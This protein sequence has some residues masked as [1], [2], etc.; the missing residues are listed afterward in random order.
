MFGAY[1]TGAGRE[2]TRPGEDYPHTYH[3]SDYYFTWS[4]GRR[5]A[6]WEY[7]ILYIRSGHGVIEFQ[8]GKPLILTAGSL[9]I[10]HPGEWHRYRPNPETGW[11]EAYVGIG[12]TLLERIVSAPFF[13]SHPIVVALPP[14]GWFD[15]ELLTLVEEIQD[16]SSERPYSLA[17][18]AITLIASVVER[19]HTF[20]TADSHNVNIRKAT[21]FIGH[22]LDEA[23]DFMQLAGNLGL[24]YSLF[25]KRFKLYTGLAPLEY[26]NALRLRRAAHLLVSS[27]APVAQIAGEL[28]F[29]SAAYFTRF[30]HQA[31]GFSPTAFRL[32]PDNRHRTLLGDRESQ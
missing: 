29:N 20:S 24:G 5:L 21:L 13:T 27:D 11:D 2:V 3:S 1:V 15:R 25:R 9:V 32:S 18:K 10:L 28:G 31:T 19:A 16:T 12:G 23:I 17:L 6:E 26:Q 7:Q 30:F 14:N 4:K 22:H 8:H